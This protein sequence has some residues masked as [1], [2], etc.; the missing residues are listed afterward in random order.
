MIQK[1][2]RFVFGGLNTKADATG[3]PL[4]DCVAL[5]DMRVVGSDIVERLGIVRVGKVAGN[6]KAMD[7]DGA[8]DY[9]YNN[10]D[11]RV[12]TLGLE[13]TVEM[14]FALDSTA[15]TQGI[16]CVGHSTP[17]MILDVTGGNIRLRVWDSAATLD[18]ITVGA[19]T[20]S[21]QTVQITRNASV[22]SARLDN[23]TATTATMSATLGARTPDGELRVARD[24]GANYCN[25]TIDY[26]RAMSIVKSNHAD[27]LVRLPNPRSAHILADYDFNGSGA[28]VY[29]RSRY[30][31]HLI[32]VDSP[33]EAP[34]LCHDP[35]PIRGLSVDME[36]TDRRKR[37]LV[38]A[39]GLYYIAT[40]E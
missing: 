34:S 33:T 14:A 1:H 3:L 15:G 4:L 13:W 24:D 17:S 9:L 35:V 23:G 26:L 39:G 32:A 27:R 7:F 2:N 40:V 5:Q 31:N 22:L 18:T 20:T 21:T 10:V 19:A 30:E 11:T 25:G 37:L 28:L 6:A 16:L 36:T 29:D 8:A 12:W 38:C